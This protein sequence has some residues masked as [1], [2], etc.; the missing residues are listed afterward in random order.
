MKRNIAKGFKRALALGMAALMAYLPVSSAIPE[1]FADNTYSIT[2]NHDE[3][4]DGNQLKIADGGGNIIAG[5][6]VTPATEGVS[7]SVKWGTIAPGTYT[8]D[9]SAAIDGTKFEVK[10]SVEFAG[11][12]ITVTNAAWSGS[13]ET[14]T[15][16]ETR[17]P[18]ELSSFATLTNV[19][20]INTAETGITYDAADKKIVIPQGTKA[21]TKINLTVEFTL[22]VTKQVTGATPIETLTSAGST[23]IKY[24]Y[25][26]DTEEV[27]SL[28]NSAD[29]KI[30]LGISIGDAGTGTITFYDEANQVIQASDVSARAAMTYSDAAW[31]SAADG[32]Q[33]YCSP[34]PDYAG[35]EITITP[36]AGYEFGGSNISD[37]ATTRKSDGSVILKLTNQ[38]EVKITIKCL[39]LN[40]PENALEWTDE[41]ETGYNS[42]NQTVAV[43]LI[44]TVAESA[45]NYTLQWARAA[46]QTADINSLTWS[47]VTKDSTDGNYHFDVN[48]ADSE[49]EK[50]YIAYRYTNGVTTS[51]VKWNAKPVQFDIAD[52]ALAKCW[53]E[54]N[55]E[56]VWEEVPGATQAPAWI[57]K[58]QNQCVIRL[59]GEDAQSGV[60]KLIYS[61][62]DKDGAAIQ[63]NVESVAD[64]DGVCSISYTAAMQ[65]DTANF[66]IKLE[67]E[68]YDKA[69]NTTGVLTK[70]LSDMIG[71]D[72]T[73]PELSVSYTNTSGQLITNLNQWQTEDVLV[74]ITATDPEGAAY[75]Q[76]SGIDR[77]QII[78]TVTGVAKDI[79]TDAVRRPDGTYQLKLSTDA[80]H[81]L[82]I[83]TYDKAGNKSTESKTEVKLDKSGIQNA[84]VTLS[85]V[86][87]DAD[88]SQFADA[89]TVYAQ[90]EAV[91]GIKEMIFYVYENGTNRLLKEQ[92][93]T[94]VQVTGNLAEASFRYE[95]A[96]D[97]ENGYV[98][99]RFLDN[100][101]KSVTEGNPHVVYS[102]QK[103]FAFNKNGANI[104][105]KG[106][107]AWTNEDV[108][109]DIQ[110]ESHSTTI[111]SVIYYVNNQR[112]KEVSVNTLSY[113]DHAFKI[114]EN[115]PMGGTQVEIV[116]VCGANAASRIETRA[117]IIVYVDKQAPT[118][119]LSGIRSGAV[120]NTNQTLQIVTNENIWNR[121][122]PISVVAEKTLDGVTTTVD[123]GAYAAEAENY[124]AR[125]TF[126]E[127][128]VYEVTVTAVDAAGNRAVQTISFTID[129]TAPVI[130]MRGASDGAYSSQPVTIQFQAI[131][132]FYETN[133]VK[134]TIERVIDGAT[135]N[136]TL[137]FT[138]TGKTSTL[139]NQFSEDGDYTITM[140]AVDRAGN[141]A[142]V[143]K[144]SFTVDCT[145]P[146]VTLTGTKDYVVTQKAVMLSFVVTESYYKTNQVEIQ[147]SRR[148]VDGK[149]ETFTVKGW[150]NAGR[151]S[152]LSQEFKEDGYYTITITARDKAGNSKQQT[153]HFTID[154]QPPVIGDLSQYDGKYLS[155]F[156]LGKRLE[157]LITE[158]TVP[159]V[160]MTLNGEAYDGGKI[161]ADGKYTLVIEVTDEVGLTA[162][163]T[164]EFVIDTIA[165]KIIFAGAE[166]RKTY[167]EPVNLNL[168]L[169]NESDT[170][171]SILINGEPYELTDG[172]TVYDLAFDTYGSY[173]VVVNTIDAAGNENSQTIKFTYA[174]HKNVALLFVVI[175]CGG[176]AAVIGGAW[177]VFKKKRA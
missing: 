59:Q 47:N 78:D 89:F 27:G 115:S 104:Q 22:P 126:T 111:T 112:V 81:Q 121:M 56:K 48:Y 97:E 99:V 133:S 131:E 128:G 77:L 143:Q 84:R 25:T 80:A 140:T 119:Q 12:D 169:E 167:T 24:R 55:G 116:A 52:P 3:Y 26:Y 41:F 145:A 157:N 138:N 57:N 28:L 101:A 42:K 90:A 146:T 86:S 58:Q 19:T 106:N 33:Y 69:G 13:L 7:A 18:L 123:M 173:E 53:V 38:S 64:A 23:A 136:Q 109:L 61:I 76:V 168:S 166:N 5:A 15:K 137:N 113:E 21:T 71:F 153:I 154:T 93:V 96:S 39:P 46:S 127:D 107:T 147:G 63:S 177:L 152:S 4:I 50:V 1:V 125:K 130:S 60:A 34:A 120:Y 85:T 40:V 148:G 87:Q 105:I 151:T 2:I 170:I 11:N 92:T 29:S 62:Y 108:T 144:L 36:N 66:P 17:L 134:I 79:T 32:F 83:V 132:S 37:S 54:A 158:L 30:T 45:G 43:S 159:T 88:A 6:T 51:D 122:Q 114:Q 162:S 161:T 72:F 165:P 94:D 172:K 155:E 171:V 139:N 74:T 75:E 117:S 103:P 129:K 163:K 67:Y 160:K 98:V 70:T 20:V 176:A 16:S 91:S 68:I 95:P 174:K 156:E 149:I 124:T 118:V 141:A 44:P 110:V 82:S 14:V 65:G 9:A 10:K 142:T 31:K 102:E 73:L 8:L 175:G 150:N 49:G 135:Y 100:A 164:I 35:A